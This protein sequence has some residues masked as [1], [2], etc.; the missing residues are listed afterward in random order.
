MSDIKEF[1]TTFN[2]AWVDN[3]IDTIVQGVTNDIHFRMATDETGVHGKEAFKIWL[4][5][6]LISDVE[7]DVTTDRMIISGDEAV[8][9]GRIRMIEQDGTQKQFTF[10]DLYRLRDGKVAELV[11]YVMNYN[12]GS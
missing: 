4:K 10:C 8:L 7:M 5:D 12:T 1:L 2:Q 9:S 3:D 6:M 11:A